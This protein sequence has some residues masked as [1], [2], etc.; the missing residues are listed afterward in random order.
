[1]LAESMG[2]V[3]GGVILGGEPFAQLDYLA[4]VDEEQP[5]TAVTALREQLEGLGGFI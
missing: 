2:E 3:I 4:F 5:D 1:M